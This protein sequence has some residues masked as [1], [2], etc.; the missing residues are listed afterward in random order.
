MAEEN[1]KEKKTKP[2]KEEKPKVKSLVDRIRPRM[3]KGVKNKKVCAEAV[4]AECKAEGVTVSRAKKEL[5]VERIMTHIG[6]IER[7]ITTKQN[8]WCSKLEI[9]EKENFRQWKTIP[10]TASA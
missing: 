2:V 6:N 8:T 1:A 3:M 4:L 9:V 10:E 7:G 5:T